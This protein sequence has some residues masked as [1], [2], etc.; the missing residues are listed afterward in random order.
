MDDI[1]K[2]LKDVQKK[3][4][5]IEKKQEMLKRIQDLGNYVRKSKQNDLLDILMKSDIIDNRN[6]STM[7]RQL[8]T[9]FPLTDVPKERTVTEEKIRKYTYTK[10][11]RCT[12]CECCKGSS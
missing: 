9:E 5:D 12:D 3:I 2:E 8:I 6:K 4:E 7:I 1:Q 10:E 11:S